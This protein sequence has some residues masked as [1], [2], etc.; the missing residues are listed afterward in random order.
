MS[1]YSLKIKTLE[2]KVENLKIEWLEQKN[3]KKL[4]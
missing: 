3:N 2:T 4:L 1:N